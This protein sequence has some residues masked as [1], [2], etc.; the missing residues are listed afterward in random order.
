MLTALR[1]KLMS[2]RAQHVHVQCYLL[3][4][5]DQQLAELLRN[6]KVW[7]HS[8]L[9][10]LRLFAAG[11]RC[12]GCFCWTD[13]CMTDDK[14]HSFLAYELLAQACPCMLL[15]CFGQLHARPRI[16]AVTAA[17]NT[18]NLI[19]IVHQ[20][21][22]ANQSS[23][24]FVGAFAPGRAYARHKAGPTQSTVMLV[25]G[26]MYKLTAAPHMCLHWETTSSPGLV[27]GLVPSPLDN[28]FYQGF[29]RCPLHACCLLAT[30]LCS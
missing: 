5:P 12:S 27:S 29:Q 30:P 11:I 3:Y 8:M 18:T 10:D 17:Y 24:I 13:L 2:V 23:M 4:C 21:W 9:C 7:P 16:T 22:L 28:V 19:L 25:T 20:I 6:K 14:L 26:P 15:A 1:Y